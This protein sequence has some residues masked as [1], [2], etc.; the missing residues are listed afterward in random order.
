MVISDEAVSQAVFFFGSDW[1]GWVCG[2]QLVSFANGVSCS[3]RKIGPRVVNE[4][5][6]ENLILQSEKIYENDLWLSKVFESNLCFSLC[7]SLP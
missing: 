6:F 7:V 3:I 5:K 2:A 1:V 4:N